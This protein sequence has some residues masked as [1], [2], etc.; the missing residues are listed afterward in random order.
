LINETADVIDFVYMLEQFGL[1]ITSRSNA[2]EMLPL[3]LMQIT[4][5]ELPCADGVIK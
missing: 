3:L 2:S 4:L 1:L 5:T